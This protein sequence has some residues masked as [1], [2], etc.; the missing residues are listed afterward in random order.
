VRRWRYELRWEPGHHGGVLSRDVATIA[1]LRAVIEWARGNPNV[2]KCAWRP[3]DY[4]EGEPAARCP[5][6]H[7]LDAPDPRQSYRLGRDVRRWACRACPGHGVTVCP[8]CRLLVVE[9]PPTH[10]CAAVDPRRQAGN[11]EV[12]TS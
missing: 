3:V 6:G 11:A 1:Q 8:T 2:V 12:A 7:R 5:D 4:L 9:P 10:G